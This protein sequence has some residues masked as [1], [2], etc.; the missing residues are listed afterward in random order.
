MELGQ[1][2]DVHWPFCANKGAREMVG[3][4]GQGQLAQDFGGVG[5]GREEAEGGIWVEG[6]QVED[7]P[8]ACEWGVG[9]RTG[10]WQYAGTQPTSPSGAD[11]PLRSSTFPCGSTCAEYST[12]VMACLFQQV[13]I[14]LPVSWY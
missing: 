11:Q 7:R 13:R 6:E 9:G 1:H 5:E 2:T 10:T 4:A 8:W 14:A 12:D 3:C